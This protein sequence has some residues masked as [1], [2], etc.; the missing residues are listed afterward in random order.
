[1]NKSL[2]FLAL[3]LSSA[4]FIAT[5]FIYQA[6]LT[7]VEPVE[8]KETAIAPTTLTEPETIPTISLA[9]KVGQL[10][11]IGH[12]ANTPLASTTNLI[13]KYHLGGVVIMSAPEKTDDIKN[14]IDSWNEVSSAPLFVSIDQEGGPVS[15]L[16]GPTFIQTSQ[17]DIT[18]E[19]AA[20]EVGKTRGMELKALG[21][22]MNFAPVLDSA[23]NPDSFMYERAFRTKESSASLAASII[24][25][26]NDASVIGVAKHFPGHDDTIDDSH[27]TLPMVPTERTE[28]DN[29]T[30]QFQELIHDQEPAAIMTAH[31]LFPNI[32]T[33][34][35]SLSHFFLTDYLRNTIN[36]T[37]LII[38][39]DMSMKA[40]ADTW[41]SEEASVRALQAGADIILFAAEPEEVERA[42]NTVITAVENNQLPTERINES[43]ERVMNLKQEIR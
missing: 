8:I 39:D 27:L 33:V 37:G 4:I 30:S 40:I 21:I 25:G 11:I 29:F 1:M 3:I 10:F 12:W 42:V 32:D 19:E 34:P 17:R 31:I 2:S 6:N 22:N 18:N 16:K 23:T 43:Y 24:R 28:L 13:E 14:W 20:Y 9:E 41:T 15:R 36:Y 38:T 7:P 26:M 35:A 5:G